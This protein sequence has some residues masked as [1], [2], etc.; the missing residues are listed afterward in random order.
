MPLNENYYH[1]LKPFT[2]KDS[3]IFNKLLIYRIPNF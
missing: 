1:I 3:I 2:A